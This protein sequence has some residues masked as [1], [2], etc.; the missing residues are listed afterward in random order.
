MF[1][2]SENFGSATLRAHGGFS[3]KLFFTNF[4]ALKML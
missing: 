3:T 4:T 1:R 2:P